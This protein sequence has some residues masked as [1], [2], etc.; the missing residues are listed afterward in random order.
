[1]LTEEKKQKERQYKAENN[2]VCILQ[3]NS[4]KKN[5]HIEIKNILWAVSS[6]KFG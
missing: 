3:H 5:N 4:Y 6:G 1:M 2:A